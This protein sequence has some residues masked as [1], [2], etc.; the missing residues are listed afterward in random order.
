MYYIKEKKR[1]LY[2]L[3]YFLVYILLKKEKQEEKYKEITF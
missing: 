1:K 2:I 3:Q